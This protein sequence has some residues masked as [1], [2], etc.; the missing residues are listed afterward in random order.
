MGGSERAAGGALDL[1][2]RVMQACRPGPGGAPYIGSGGTPCSRQC[3]WRESLKNV[4]ERS[5]TTALGVPLLGCGSSGLGV[6]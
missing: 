3:Y 6:T 1:G 4:C 2:W 5:D